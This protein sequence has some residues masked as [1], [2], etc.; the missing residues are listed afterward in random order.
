MRGGDRVA[1]RVRVAASAC[2]V[3]SGLFI[4]GAG[5]AIALADPG[6][7]YGKSD[8]RQGDDSLGDVMRRALGL[9]TATIR[10]RVRAWASA[11]QSVGK[12]PH[13]AGDV[14][15]TDDD[16]RDADD[17]ERRLRVRRTHRTAG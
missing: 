8:D 6:P 11:A 9:E 13:R 1:S 12:R 14:R 16:E 4:A 5:G 15:A 10:R 7:G 3:A 17:E 2:L